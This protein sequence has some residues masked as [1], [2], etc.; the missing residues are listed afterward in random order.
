M[1]FM[2]TSWALMQT[3]KSF[4]IMRDAIYFWFKEWYLKNEKKGK[5]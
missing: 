3:R 4:L 5:S 1:L 2:S